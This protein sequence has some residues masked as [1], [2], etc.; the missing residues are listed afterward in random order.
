MRLKRLVETL[1]NR[2]DN[3]LPSGTDS[4]PKSHPNDV[5]LA[6]ETMLLLHLEVRAARN[7]DSSNAQEIT[8]EPAKPATKP[9]T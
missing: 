9:K 1:V 8:K 4:G 6:L 5:V 2:R 7:S 3:L